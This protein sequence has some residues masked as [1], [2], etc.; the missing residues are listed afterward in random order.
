MFVGDK[1]AIE[2][3]VRRFEILIDLFGKTSIDRPMDCRFVLTDEY[4]KGN[5]KSIAD[6]LTFD[7]DTFPRFS[8]RGF[9]AF[10]RT[11][12]YKNKD[13][14]FDINYAGVSKITPHNIRK[15]KKIL[16][17]DWRKL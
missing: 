14:G 3:I 17:V 16:Y 4:G 6:Y 12:F 15:R 5:W 7:G 9:Q 11:F 2:K 8:K 13:T 1:E 10:V